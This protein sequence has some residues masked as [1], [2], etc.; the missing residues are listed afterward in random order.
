MKFKNR[1]IKRK[2]N[3]GELMTEYFAGKNQNVYVTRGELFQIT[4]H[5][6]EFDRKKR[7][8]WLR[9][10]AWWDS[11]WDRTKREAQEIREI[12]TPGGGGEP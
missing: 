1:R 7:S 4:R 6:I 11:Q 10:R 3:A 12:V 8:V 2:G 5:M 9:V